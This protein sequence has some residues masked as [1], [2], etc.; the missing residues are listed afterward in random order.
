MGLPRGRRVERGRLRRPEDRG[1]HERGRRRVLREPHDL[2]PPHR[3][4][5]RCV[6]QCRDAHRRL[7]PAGA[8]AR[9]RHAPGRGRGECRGRLHGECR[10][11]HRTRARRHR[12]ARDG[13]SRAQWGLGNRGVRRG[14]PPLRERQSH[15]RRDLHAAAACGE[16]VCECGLHHRQLRRRARG[17]FRRRAE[18]AGRLQARLRLGCRG[19]HPPAL[20]ARRDARL[21]WRAHRRLGHGHDELAGR[22]AVCGGRDRALRRHGGR[23]AQHHHHR[24]RADTAAR[25]LR[26]DRRLRHLRHARPRHRGAHAAREDRPRPAHHRGRAQLRRRHGHRRGLARAL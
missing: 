13:E 9:P 19:H 20:R 25:D 21:G 24:R 12:H 11:D 26:H 16:H 17:D 7:R 14:R 6:A 4:R 1:Q 5:A 2:P 23:H 3:D 8:D 18:S 10:R 15:A 22:V